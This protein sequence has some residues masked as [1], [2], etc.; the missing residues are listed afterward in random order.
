MN[1]RFRWLLVVVFA[2]AMAWVESAVVFYLRVFIDRVQPYQL[3]PLPISFGFGQVELIREAATMLMLVCIGWLAGSNWRAR[4]GYLLLAFG[5][6]DILYYVYLMVLSGWPTSF[7]DWDI[8][9]LIP[10]PWWGPVLAPVSIAVLMV[11]TGSAITQIPAWP[12][13]IAWMA[14]LLGAL[15]VLYTFMA[16]A[17]SALGDGPQAVRDILPASFNWP[18]FG[19]ALLC[20]AV[21]ALDMFWNLRMKTTPGR[22]LE[23]NESILVQREISHES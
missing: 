7:W 15:L 8:L 22:K 17:L 4:F 2:A 5:V 6:W 3:D 20:M 23:Q 13:P 19:I 11:I 14:S 9:F 21:P 1:E 10:L 12:R 16:D 18:L